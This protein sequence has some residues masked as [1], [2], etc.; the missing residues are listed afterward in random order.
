MLRKMS[1]TYTF[2]QDL[3]DKHSMTINLTD[4]VKDLADLYLI[5][6][7]NSQPSIKKALLRMKDE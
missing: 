3:Y 2:D 7:L 6:P 4:T 5:D 1:K